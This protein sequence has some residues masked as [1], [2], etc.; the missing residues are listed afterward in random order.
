MAKYA[1]EQKKMLLDFLKAHPEDSFTV[2]EIFLGMKAAY[3]EGVTGAS[4]VYRLVT[5]L[6]EEGCLR[7]FVKGN[8]RHFVYQIVDGEHCHA[9]LHLR[10]T[11]CGRL[12][13]LGEAL[14]EEI[15]KNVFLE[16]CF[17][18]SEGDTVLLGRCESCREG[19]GADA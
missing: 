12:L 19:G 17:A 15:L 5:G 18:V 2:E 4:T 11:H 1:T 13:H 16:S 10:C 6:L 7:R 8:S 14:S 3:G 9:H